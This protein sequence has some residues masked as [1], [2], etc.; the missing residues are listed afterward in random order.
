MRSLWNSPRIR[1][2]FLI[3]VCL[4]MLAASLGSYVRNSQG[5]ENAL[6]T[7][8]AALVVMSAL[9]LVVGVLAGRSMLKEQRSR[10][11]TVFIATLTLAILA[12]QSWIYF[13][14]HDSFRILLY[15]VRDLLVT[16]AS[17]W[18]TIMYMYREQVIRN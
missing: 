12:L 14:P 16:G 15:L 11:K 3:A 4:L 13:A 5:R 8:C 1:S 17:F 18:L 9:W 7:C 10:T 6:V 2:A